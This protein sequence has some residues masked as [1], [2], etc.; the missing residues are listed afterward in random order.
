MA[1]RQVSIFSRTAG[2]LMMMPRRA[3]KEIEPMMATGMAIKSGHGVATTRA[4]KKR[5]ASPLAAQAPR[6]MATARGGV[7]RTQLIAQPP[8]PRAML[9]RSTHHL[10]DFRIAR[11][12]RQFAGQ[13][14]QDRFTVDGP[15]EHF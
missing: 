3:A 11:I 5:V 13:N 6:A 7:E 14:A 10:H 2:S 12:H 8:Q 9:R 4:A 15:G 1:V